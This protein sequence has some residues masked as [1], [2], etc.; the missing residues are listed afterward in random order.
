MLG[1]LFRPK[2]QHQN[3]KV[4][5]RTVAEG[6]VSVAACFDIAL[7]DT[8][9]EV[10]EQA[11]QRIES[12]ESLLA[13]VRQ[14]PDLR[15]AATL[16]LVAL[17]EDADEHDDATLT[18]VLDVIDDEPQRRALAQQA[19]SA[20]V[21]LA[22]IRTIDDEDLLKLT[23]TGDKAV[24]VR[25]AALDRVQTEAALSEIA[26]YTRG[27]DKTIAKLAE[28]RLN[29]I[30]DRQQRSEDRERLIAELAETVS[31][32]SPIDEPA[33]QR[34]MATWDSLQHEASAEQQRLFARAKAT[35][36]ARLAEQKQLEREDR[37]RKSAR[38]DLLQR[39]QAL[40]TEV[41]VADPN[42]ISAAIRILQT[43]WSEA[44]PLQDAWAERRFQDEWLEKTTVLENRLRSRRAL[45]QQEN[46][47]NSAIDN[48]QQQLERG[49]L[50]LRQ[51]ERTER[52]SAET[53]ASLKDPHSFEK[54]IHRLRT[55]TER[56]RGQFEEE[57]K[58]KQSLRKQ[59]KN[60]I[61]TLE[62]ALTEKALDQASAAHKAALRILQE[63]GKNLPG[64]IQKLERRLRQV[65][66]QLRELQSWRNWGTDHAREELIEAAK[67]LAV[68]AVDINQRAKE[69]NRLRE[70]WKSLGGSGHGVQ[71]MWKTFDAAC[72]AAY[73]PIKAEHTKEQQAREQNLAVRASI[74]ADVESLVEDTDWESPDWRAVDKALQS[75][76]RKWRDTGGVPHKA[77]K[78]IKTRFD[79]A[80]EDLDEHLA[81]ERRHNFLQ[82]QA[83]VRDAEALRDVEDNRAAVVEARNLRN[84]WQVTVTSKPS[85]ERKLW[86]AFNKAM[87]AVFARDREARDEFKAELDEHRVVAETLCQRVEQL[88]DSEAIAARQKRAELTQAEDEFRHLGALPKGP[89][90]ALER[91]FGQAVR[92]AQQS[93]AEADRAYAAQA[94]QQLHDLHSIC[95]RA[96]TL[97]HSQPPDAQAVADI[98]DAWEAAA[99]PETYKPTVEKLT[100]RYIVARQVLAGERALTVL[101]DLDRHAEIRETLCVDLEILRGMDSP[102]DAGQL[103]MARQVDLLEDA[104]KGGEKD[105][106]KTIRRLQFD[107]LSVGA[108]A[109]EKRQ[110]LD[111]RFARLFP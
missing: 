63:L 110:P 14:S 8:A 77:W 34:M 54:P 40:T 24:D 71:A 1:K 15:R 86:Q 3:A 98:D 67:T 26:K 60:H 73:A 57:Q 35:L 25:R 5:A 2:W 59:L 47:L 97:A 19:R 51:V 50:S 78:A 75:A 80:I 61:E 23:V 36:D 22:A 82:R 38:E 96:E 93:I 81:K 27:R 102:A 91:R 90:E 72:T 88:A 58:H 31:S 79:R 84:A 9:M 18:S 37:S 45:G 39:L 20:R 48:L 44:T 6:K 13:L 64:P 21:R 65:E 95:E 100:Q 30:H 4:R 55:L 33:W 12:V 42:D 104:M 41:D 43:G 68:S 11:I 85:E 17:I 108:V 52:N 46:R 69:L 29:E 94:L 101:G 70:Q 16:R 109:P 83:L 49:D 53:I 76:R 105:K 89:R 74:C 106:D 28:Q 111:E 10:R 87:D 62:A 32:H 92:K 99:K 56:L 66:P 107:Y 103:R 7:N